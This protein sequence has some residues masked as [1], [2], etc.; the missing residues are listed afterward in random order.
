[1]LSQQTFN[2]PYLYRPECRRCQR[3]P[4]V[5]EPEPSPFSRRRP[6]ARVSQ[7]VDLSDAGRGSAHRKGKPV[8]ALRAVARNGSQPGL[9][10]LRGYAAPHIA[11]SPPARPAFAAAPL[12]RDNSQGPIRGSPG[13]GAPPP[14]PRGA[15]RTTRLGRTFPRLP[16][17]TEWTES[18]RPVAGA[19]RISERRG[20]A[21]GVRLS[22]RV[23]GNPEKV[24]REWG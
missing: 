8:A 4:R 14:P 12:K 6:L 10:V 24:P 20:E 21:S 3:P 11:G 15:A 2:V 5:A 16:E 23:A 13:G 19:R 1:M 18:A 7:T 17:T 9:D 22:G